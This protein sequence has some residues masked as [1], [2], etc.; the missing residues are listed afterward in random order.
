M[1]SNY[2]TNCRILGLNCET[3]LT[4]YS[5]PPGERVVRRARR[6]GRALRHGCRLGM[7]PYSARA[8]DGRGLLHSRRHGVGALLHPRCRGTGSPLTLQAQVR[9]VSLPLSDFL[10]LRSRSRVWA[11][12]QLLDY[13]DPSIR[14]TNCWERDCLIP[15]PP[16]TTTALRFLLVMGVPKVIDYWRLCVTCST[17]VTKVVNYVHNLSAGCGFTIEVTWPSVHPNMHSKVI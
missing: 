1:K 9:H 14:G 5:N 11:M 10:K 4:R 12:E 15:Q 17:C 8:A 16:F 3:N 6:Q 2:K 13:G 7:K